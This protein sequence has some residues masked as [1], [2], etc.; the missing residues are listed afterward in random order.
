MAISFEKNS[1]LI[2]SKSVDLPDNIIE[3]LVVRNFIIVFVD[4]Q[5]NKQ[6]KQF[7]YDGGN[8]FCYDDTGCFKWQWKSKNVMKI[9]VEKNK[10][11]IYDT[12]SLGYDCVVDVETGK[13]LKMEPTK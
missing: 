10:L 3:I 13:I 1:L 5:Y 2:H 8:V 6:T 11:H 7:N 9:W 4:F 12:A